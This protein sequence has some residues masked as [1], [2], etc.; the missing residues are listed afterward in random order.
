M[1]DDV[2]VMAFDGSDE[3]EYCW[4]PLSTVRQPVKEM[5]EAGV[6]AIIGAG[7]DEPSR[8]QVFDCE[9]I[10]RRSCGCHAEGS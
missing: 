9:L 8:N 5:A 2:A 10:L 7:R 3:A 4:P 1:P 6:R